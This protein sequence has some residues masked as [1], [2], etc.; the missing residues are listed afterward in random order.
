MS[1][2]ADQMLTLLTRIIA[3]I[4]RPFRLTRRG[5]SFG[6]TA[7]FRLK[8]PLSMLECLSLRSDFLLS[9]FCV[10]RSRTTV[11]CAG[12]CYYL[13]LRPFANQI[14]KNTLQYCR[15]LL[16]FAIQKHILVRFNIGWTPQNYLCI[17]LG[18]GKI[19]RMK[20]NQTNQ[21]I[22]TSLVTGQASFKS[23]FRMFI[24]FRLTPGSKLSHVLTNQA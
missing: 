7:T 15:R 2:L 19:V 23:S 4:V 21:T 13:V 14:N 20:P 6:C 17:W 3:A 5:T 24:L 22:D 11:C 9:R 8:V 16:D 10:K 12:T 18:R 1:S